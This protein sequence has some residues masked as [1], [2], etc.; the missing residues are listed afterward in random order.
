M[1]RRPTLRREGSLRRNE[2][3]IRCVLTIEQARMDKSRV[4]VI[5]E[6]NPRLLGFRLPLRHFVAVTLIVAL[7]CVG[8]AAVDHYPYYTERFFGALFK[9][10]VTFYPSIPA[11]T[12]VHELGHLLMGLPFG[13]PVTEVRLGGGKNRRVIPFGTNFRLILGWLPV[14][15]H[16]EFRWLPLSRSRRI[17]MYGAGVGATILAAIVVCAFPFR[18]QF[19]YQGGVL[20]V[21]V[22][23]ALGNIFER[24]PD[25][26]T[27][28]WSDGEAIRGLWKYSTTA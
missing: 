5:T 3:L 20:L 21:V 9:V 14:T 25:K 12:V 4:K 15:G 28:R 13:V 17:A 18:G 11:T 6:M 10:I 22:F 7:T 24:H 16:V 26:V 8:V 19:A 1:I 23:S 2:D 27:G